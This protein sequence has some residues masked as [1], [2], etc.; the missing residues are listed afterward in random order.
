MDKTKNLKYTLD[1]NNN[2]NNKS[3]WKKEKLKSRLTAVKCGSF[4]SQ[5]HIKLDLLY[6]K[7]DGK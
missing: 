3:D 5:F 6:C 1:I 7:Y 2:N 4:R